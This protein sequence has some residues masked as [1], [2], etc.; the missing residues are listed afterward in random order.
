MD[1]VINTLG[2]ITNA[3]GGAIGGFCNKILPE[4][5]KKI[6]IPKPV[7]DWNVEKIIDAR[8]K[9]FIAKIIQIASYVFATIAIVAAIVTIDALVCVPAAIGFGITAVALGILCWKMEKSKEKFF[10]GLDDKKKSQ[11]AK[12]NI[13]NLFYKTPVK[14]FKNVEDIKKRLSEINTIFEFEAIN[15]NYLD[16]FNRLKDDL[17]SDHSL[18]VA[19][20]EY[21]ENAETNDKIKYELDVVKKEYK[22]KLYGPSKLEKHLTVKWNKIGN[23]AEP[24]N[25]GSDLTIS[26][27]S[28]ESCAKEFPTILWKEKKADESL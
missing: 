23:P 1:T 13:Y 21:N 5:V 17:D 9:E 26:Y 28:G 4:P 18:I 20:M 22:D 12:E 7:T 10:E 2:N 25:S 15:P 3:V 24:D 6:L 19:I 27:F 11:L 14:N 8:K 16:Q